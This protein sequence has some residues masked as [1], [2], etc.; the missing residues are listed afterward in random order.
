MG[1][2]GSAAIKPVTVPEVLQR[3]VE[4]YPDHPAL[5]FKDT[6]GAW[7]TLNYREYQQKVHNI[8]QAFIKLG[9]EPRNS[10]GIVAFNCPEWFC[11]E[12]AA[13]HAGAISAGIYTTNSPHGVWHVLHTSNANIAIVDDADQMEKVLQIRDKLTALKAVVQING[14]LKASLSHEEGYYKWSDLED[15]NLDDVEEEYQRRLANICANECCCLIYTS[16]TTGDPKP[17]MLSHDNIT[18]DSYLLGK[19]WGFAGEV[20]V[21]YLPLSHIAA[22]IIDIFVGLAYATTVY[23]ADRYA[24]KKPLN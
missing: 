20:I 7:E 8:A 22:K 18:W 21:S 3:N 17:A 14:I 11:S 1:N 13:I 10:V 9:L 23:F 6:N 15:M 19:S 5:V 12:L 16:G 2:D 24:L 4:M